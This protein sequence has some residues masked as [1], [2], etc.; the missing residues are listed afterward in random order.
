MKDHILSYHIIIL[1]HILLIN[2]CIDRCCPLQALLH[3]YFFSSPLPAHHS[4]LP[5]PQRQGRSPRQRLQAPPTDF[6]PDLPV[7]RSVIDPA[8]LQ[9]HAACL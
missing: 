6:S 2:R 9:G 8:M 5:I 7:Q 1:S 3:P 4:E